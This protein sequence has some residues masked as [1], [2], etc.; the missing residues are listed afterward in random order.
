MTTEI[1]VKEA[2]NSKEAEMLVLGCML[3]SIQNLSIGAE[4]LDDAEFYFAQHKIIFRA[5]K[6][7]HKNNRPADVHLICEELKRQD[8]LKDAGGTDYLVTLA[9]Y[10]GTSTN[11][12]EYTRLVKDKSILRKII[13]A[14]QSALKTA[15]EEPENVFNCLNEAQQLFS[16]IES[17]HVDRLPILSS[18][19]RFEEHKEMLKQCRGKEYLGLRINGFDVINENL[20]G[21]RKL[22]LLAAAPNVG[23]TALTVQWGVGVLEAE[24]SACVVYISLEMSPEE[25]FTR[26]MLYLSGLDYDTYVLGKFKGSKGES[27]GIYHS[28]DELKQIT[29][30]EEKIK[31]FGHRLQIIDA[32]RG[33]TAELAIEYIKRIKKKSNCT[34]ALVVVD[35]LQ[36]WPAP[37][38][39]RSQS[40]VETDKWRI[41]QMKKIRDYLNEENQDPIVVI[42]EARKPPGGTEEWGG[43][44][45]DVMGSARGTYTPDVVILQSQIKAED[46]M[47]LCEKMKIPYPNLDKG[48][49]KENGEK[50]VNFLAT[51][52]I[53]ISGLKVAKARDGMKKFKIEQ[54][55]YFRKNKFTN[56][57]WPDITSLFTK[58]QNENKPSWNTTNEN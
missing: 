24:P 40:D 26:M 19:E 5:L 29:E 8:E 45:S 14:A 16:K 30:A 31:K 10:A 47:I 13:Y 9:Q 18:G 55:F 4:A 33:I 34:R 51:R 7:S 32:S 50:I 15:L 36:V 12:D 38:S 20:N 17:G 22:I 56:V 54:A 46:V 41:G 58:E 42:S 48:K 37:E 53:S 43:D 49:K 11:I 23:K 3:T 2:P 39:Q 35:Y 6:S 28:A 21:L 25:I 57:P 1:K 27:L 44:L 52:G